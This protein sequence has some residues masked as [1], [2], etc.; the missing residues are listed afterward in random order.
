MHVDWPVS[1]SVCLSVSMC[2]LVTI[3]RAAKMTEP[4]EI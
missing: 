2:L 3:A 1:L 4:I